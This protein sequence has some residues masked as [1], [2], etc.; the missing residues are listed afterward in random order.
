MLLFSGLWS[1][2]WGESFLRRESGRKD[3]QKVKVSQLHSDPHCGRKKGMNYEWKW[4]QQQQKDDWTKSWIWTGTS[5]I[6]PVLLQELGASGDQEGTVRSGETRSSAHSRDHQTVPDVRQTS[7]PGGLP[8][9][10]GETW[11]NETHLNTRASTTS[12]RTTSSLLNLDD[13]N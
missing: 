7:S 1:R 10:G 5:S 11:E 9:Q 3:P 2:L 13:K 12:C 4:D 6:S 8:G